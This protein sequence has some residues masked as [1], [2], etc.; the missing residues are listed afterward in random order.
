MQKLKEIVERFLKRAEEKPTYYGFI[1][2]TCATAG[3]LTIDIIQ[4]GLVLAGW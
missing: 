1:V 4:L 2:A 3:Y